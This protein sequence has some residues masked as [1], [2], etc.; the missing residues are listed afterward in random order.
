MIG[1]QDNDDLGCAYV[2]N[3]V[4]YPGLKMSCNI[5]FGVN[6]NPTT[7]FTGIKI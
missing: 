2:S 7:S 1:I 4:D 5:I 6:Q 3:M